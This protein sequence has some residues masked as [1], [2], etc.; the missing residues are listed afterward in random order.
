VAKRIGNGPTVPGA[1][2]VGGYAN[3]LGVVRSLGGRGVP[4]AVIRTAGHDIAHL[5]R[6]AAESHW[7]PDVDRHPDA[8]LDIL[9]ANA[10]RWGGRVL[11][12]TNDFALEVLAREKERLMASYRVPVPPWEVANR[13]LDKRLTREAAGKVGI[14][15]PRALGFIQAG[16]TPPEV[17]EFPVLVKPV[18]G[19]RFAERM[20]KKLLV[21]RNAAEL[22]RAVDEARASGVS[23][24]I[25]ELIPGP[26]DFH[27]NYQTYRTPAGECV[28]DFSLRKLRQSPPFFGVARAAEPAPA[29]ELR[30][31]TH[32]LL[33]RLEWQGFASASYK[34]D[35][36]TGRFVLIEVNGRCVQTHGVGRRAGIDYPFMIYSG[37]VREK[38]EGIQPNG[39]NGVWIH[40]HADL[41]Y[42][43]F[44]A[45]AEGLDWGAFFASYRRPKTFAV[46][47]AR[48]PAP[49]FAQWS[50]TVWRAL[51]P[52][53]RHRMLGRVQPPGRS[54]LEA[55]AGPS[56]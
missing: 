2:V 13:V 15:C 28:G 26:D 23:C 36:R 42:T 32:E 51:E 55:G 10:R 16:S 34:R 9:E 54:D 31:P 7:V 21:A 48:D 14:D 35:A 50:G 8:L 49:F 43:A 20:G 52:A 40:L 12:P 39:W 17:T 25:Q 37:A 33:K 6:Y 30:E 24:E 27:Y 53:E 38:P 46:W 4:V 45:R 41:L 29:P 18:V 11:I 1:V 3:G 19:H 22:D 44:Y 5:S 56:P 47:S